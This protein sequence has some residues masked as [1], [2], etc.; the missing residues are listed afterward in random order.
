MT[1]SKP[2]S[3]NRI[4]Q[5]MNLR[6]GE[7]VEVRSAEEILGTL[8][9]SH[10]LDS[11]PFMPEMLQYC[12]KRVRVYKS[13]HKTCDTI[14]SFSIRRMR[15][16]VHLETLRCDGEAHGGCQAGCLLF[17]KEAWLKRV[18]GGQATAGSSD[19]QSEPAR[20]QAG[21]AVDL[22]GLF[23]ATTS[24]VAHGEPE[25]YRCQ[26]TEMRNATSETRRRDRFDP[27]F[28]VKDITTGNV[29]VFDFIRFGLFAILNSFLLRWFDHRYPRTCGLAGAKTPSCELNLQPGELVQV[30]SKDEI[31]K[32]LNAKLRN[33]GLGFDVEMVPYCEKGQ[34]KVLR[35]VE[36]IINEKTGQMM[37]LPNPCIILDGVI[38][39]G[40]YSH[41]RMF[42]PRSVFPYFRE[43]W[44]K[45]VDDGV[46][47]GGAR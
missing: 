43:I 25:R 7:W 36:K 32:T 10:C 40:N 11:L 23:R 12:G 45:R 34:Y 42:C 30:R 5:S 38:C 6:A 19:T 17:W 27:R 2:Q 1:L 18:P 14:E 8:D 39:S 26:A 4:D 41:N 20:R 44:L 13:A 46:A 29:K 21:A 3:V 37:K 31:M 47:G 9:E 28:Y 16:A 35:S 24:P 22:R 15:N 33:R